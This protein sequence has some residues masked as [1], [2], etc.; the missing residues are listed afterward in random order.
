MPGYL[1]AAAGLRNLAPGAFA[2]A[3]EDG[4]E[5]TPQAVAQMT[6]L[7]T[8]QRVRVLLY[9]SQAVSPI[10]TRIRAAAAQAGI[11]VVGVSETMPPQLT[12]Q[13]WQLGQARA[14]DA[15]LA[16]TGAASSRRA[17]S[18]CASAS[19]RS[20]TASTSSSSRA[21]SWPCSARTAPARRR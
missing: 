11:P 14:L 1:I 18:R 5:P 9:N 13:Q 21:S 6:A 12:F 8:G 4:S 17:A 2:R 20:G 10:T 15:A 3:I 19:A 7:M 16:V